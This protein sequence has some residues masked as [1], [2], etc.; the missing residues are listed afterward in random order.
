M[1]YVFFLKLIGLNFILKVHSGKSLPVVVKFL[2]IILLI[3]FSAPNLL[4]AQEGGMNKGERYLLVINS[5][6]EALENFIIG[7]K[8][9]I[10]LVNRN[11]ISGKI[12]SI[13]SN[14]FQ[15][16]A[17]I[18]KLSDIRKIRKVKRRIPEIII[19]SL[20]IGGG[21]TTLA[22][23]SKGD[24]NFK[25]I[26]AVGALGIGLT[27]GGIAILYPFWIKI[28]PSRSVKIITKT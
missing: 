13:D 19:G 4:F 14:Q 3:P 11:V 2:I 1:F 8:V 9:K 16:N 15:V 28:G 6:Q 23:L 21:I 17:Q 7:E 10:K 22:I 12:T 20:L 24:T 25:D 18:V 5:Q 26:P 27:A